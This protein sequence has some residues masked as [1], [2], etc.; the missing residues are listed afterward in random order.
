VCKKCA[1]LASTNAVGK[2]AAADC[3]CPVNTFSWTDT[4]DTTGCQPCPVN[5]YRN[6]VTIVAGETVD[7]KGRCT[8][9]RAHCAS[10]QCQHNPLPA[11][12]V[13]KAELAL[14]GLPSKRIVQ[15]RHNRHRRLCLQSQLL[16]GL[17]ASS[18]AEID[19]MHM[20]LRLLV[21]IPAWQL[22]L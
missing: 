15:C 6:L 8:P 19:L 7:L 17:L 18:S 21:L 12:I 3:G 14:L 16:V 4:P 9:S 5:S 2:T 20:L 13:Q 1:D 11:G 10:L 22:Q